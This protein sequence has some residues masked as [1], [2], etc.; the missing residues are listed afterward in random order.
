MSETTTKKEVKPLNPFYASL[1]MI[2]KTTGE[3]RRTKNAQRFNKKVNKEANRISAALEGV[4]HLIVTDDTNAYI[5]NA[6]QVELLRS[7]ADNLPAMIL[8]G[9][10]V[11]PCPDELIAYLPV[12]FQI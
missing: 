7:D 1:P 6:D 5:L 8:N 2:F 12:Q 3:V 11:R 4:T 9:F 10:T